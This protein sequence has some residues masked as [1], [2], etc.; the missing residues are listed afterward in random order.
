MWGIAFV[1]LAEL[2]RSTSFRFTASLTAAFLLAY[3]IAG[4]VGFQAINVDLKSRVIQSVEL[5]V[6]RYEDTFQTSG[7]SGLIAAVQARLPRIDAD[8][9]FIWL[10]SQDGQTIVGHNSPVVTLLS[11]GLAAGAELG[12]EEEE[13]FWIVARNFGDLR[14]VTGQSFEESD[15]IERAVLGA[16]GGATALTVVLAV[17]SGA[18]L[19]RRAQRRL[20]QISDTLESISL[21]NMS[22]RVP[23]SHQDDDLSRLSDQIN[24]ALDQLELTVEGI[25]Q[26]ST[27]IA[28]D[29]RTPIGRLGIRLEELHEETGDQLRLRDQIETAISDVKQIT[30]TFDSLL[31]I[32]QIEAGARKSRFRPV[33][34]TEIAVALYDAYLPVAEEGGQH[35]AISITSHATPLVFGDRDLLTQLFANLLEN[36][37]RHCPSGAHICL[38]V[39]SEHKSV[40]MAVSDDGPGIPLDEHENV[41]LR[42]YRLEKS[43][44]T[45]G[46]GLGLALVKAIGKLHGAVV[47]LDDNHPG[48]SVRLKFQPYHQTALRTSASE[49]DA[50]TRGDRSPEQS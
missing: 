34:L 22:S 45:P 33:A 13:Q 39:S 20:D 5:A 10:G 19:A 46:S 15:S 40:W 9:E 48:L 14:L 31:R 3:L 11:T 23:F 18:L 36:A 44:H 30:T 27:D 41:T 4:F 29:L 2:R 28:H 42:F 12:T 47:C 38:E 7:R 8:D 50:T 26:V 17:L 49:R 25:R 16:F 24:V 21:G 37:L 1:R 32:A 43:R 35:L 6:E